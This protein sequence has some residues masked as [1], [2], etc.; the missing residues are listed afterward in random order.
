[1]P[2]DLTPTDHPTFPYHPAAL[3]NPP[4]EFWRGR[5]VSPWRALRRLNPL[6]PAG[7]AAVV[8]ALFCGG[9]WT[10]AITFLRHL[11]AGAH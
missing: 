5:E 4:A 1:M 7:W 2:A 9:A 8:I 3:A 6:S 11:I 10:L